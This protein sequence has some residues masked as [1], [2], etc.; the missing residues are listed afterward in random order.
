MECNVHWKLDVI[1]LFFKLVSRWSPKLMKL[2]TIVI[3]RNFLHFLGNTKLSKNDILVIH[4][5]LCAFEI[6][7]FSGKCK[8]QILTEVLFFIYFLQKQILDISSSVLKIYQKKQQKKKSFKITVLNH[9]NPFLWG[10][11]IFCRYGASYMF[12]TEQNLI[13][14]LMQKILWKMQKCTK[15]TIIGYFHPF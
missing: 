4:T 3:F 7:V 2:S 15:I 9:F 12:L 6:F 10:H 1:S 11:Q 13:W 14:S 5:F 8:V